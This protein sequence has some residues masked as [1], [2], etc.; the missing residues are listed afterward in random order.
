MSNK[1]LILPGDGIGPEVMKEVTRIIEWFNENK[2][3]NAEF[4]FDEV[5]RGVWVWK[6]DTAGFIE[7]EV[8]RFQV[9]NFK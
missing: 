9:E 1:I 5:G 7:G 3:F 6:G 4:E 8:G 2:G